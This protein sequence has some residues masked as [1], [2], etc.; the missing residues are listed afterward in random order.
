MKKRFT[1][2]VSLLLLVAF[3]LL[4]VPPR[5]HACSPSPI[6][7][8]FTFTVHPDVPFDDFTRGQIGVL[9]PSYARSYLVAAYRQLAG[10]NFNDEERKALLQFWK[11]RLDYT[12]DD[13]AAEAISVWTDARAHVPLVGPA[14]KIEVYR[15]REKPNEYEQYLNCQP[16][17]FQ[18]AAATLGERII[19]Y[20]A[21]H[22]SLKEWVTAQDEVFAN[23]SE[24]QHVPGKLGAGADA[25]L[26]ADR[27]YQIAAA[28][29]YAS[30]FD[31][32]AQAF[33]EIARDAASPWRLQARYLS[34]RSLVRAAS[35]GPEAKKEETLTQ[36]EAQLG[37][38]LSDKNQPQIHAASK[39]LLNLVRLRLHPEE[40][41]RELAREVLRAN[42]QSTIRQDLWDYT[43]LLDK[44]TGE[45]TDEETE[46]KP[47]TLPPVT[48]K[49]DLTDWVST[50]Q[51]ADAGALEH[52]L[53]KWEQTSNNAWLIAALTKI[54]SSHPKATTLVG[55]GLKVKA[56][57]PAFASVIFH[58]VRLL[59]EAGR[60][61]E[62][63]DQLDDLL[64]RQTNH[65]P[66]SSINLLLGLRMK[67]A[68]DLNEF[69]KY[70]QR[71]P[72]A[73]S[74][75]D[76]GREIPADLKELEDNKELQVYAN[77]RAM[78]DQD[79][80]RII[81]EGL[82][83]SVLKDAASLASLPPHLR[84]DLAIA[85]WVRSVLYDEREVG[86]EIA[87]VVES[88]APEL[89]GY[90]DAEV[91]ASSPD[92]RKFSALY[93]ILKFP[94]MQPFVTAGIGRRTPLKEMDSYRDNWWCSFET[95]MRAATSENDK[96]EA[97]GGDPVKT[98]AGTIAVFSPGFL[99]KPQRAAAA[100][101]RA[102][103]A[104]LGTAPN[105][106]CRLAVEWA[107]KSPDDPRVPEALHLAVKS[108][109]YGCADEQ[110]GPLS[111]AAFQLLHKK[112]PDSP[113][114]AKT[115]YWFKNS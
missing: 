29:F 95:L 19:Q 63:R 9:Q 21:A 3:S 91:A 49:D 72:S 64:A 35:L 74:W 68:H 106:L 50:F 77:G 24:G 48:R 30:Q 78:F 28:H 55:A 10:A 108:T 89:K 100:S 39:R 36:A 15:M 61:T 69:F 114:T 59:I 76:D 54:N 42:S 81:N 65:L 109:R 93:A 23:C 5:I 1:K 7:A 94:G 88:L 80:T 103:L 33:T 51:D 8:I 45:G 66:S 27:D 31:E 97:A 17:A 86:A 14:P 34:A 101:E 96:E 111:K 52:A 44:F 25:L 84:R 82:P 75:N 99:E 115:P 40:R 53:Q 73:L 107:N 70:A 104:A 46:K 112:Y 92:A 32:A 37:Q 12:W 85:A 110:T 67:L 18:T 26:R 38:I 102:R 47:S 13:H 16:D 83:L 105:Y 56:D 4:A 2:S 113:W 20:G 62:A 22:P 98:A 71:V 57:S 11:E 90:L 60:K 43:F 41:L 6:E 79:A 87:P 58:S